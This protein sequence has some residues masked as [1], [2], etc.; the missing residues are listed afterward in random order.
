MS[1]HIY[2]S[3]KGWRARIDIGVDPGTGKRR[4]RR[5]GPYGSRREAERAMAKVITGIQ[6]GSGVD[7][8]S[9]NVTV[10]EYLRGQWL[11]ARELRGLKPTTLESRMAKLGIKRQR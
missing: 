5:I 3:A 1:G 11:P 6:E 7:P 2:K 9:G 4:Q 10:A 8:R